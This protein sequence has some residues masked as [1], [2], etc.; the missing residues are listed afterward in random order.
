MPTIQAIR[1]DITSLSVMA[2]VNAANTPL[3]GGAGVDGAIHRAAGPKLLEACRD[4]QGCEPGEAKITPGFDLNAEFVIA[5]VGPV[6]QGGD[7][8]EAEI[9]ASCYRQCIRLAEEEGITSIAFPAIST[10]AYGYPL[11]LATQIAVA[12]VSQ[13]VQG[14]KVIGEVIFCCFSKAHLNEY[15]AVLMQPN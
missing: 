9:L 2:I 1:A 5:T 8:G 13:A 14:T 15:R 12:T 11:D 6:W 10:G 4:L 3:L 7:C